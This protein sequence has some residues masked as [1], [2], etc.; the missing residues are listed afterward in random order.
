MK[1]SSTPVAPL[2]AAVPSALP[3]PCGGPNRCIG[4]PT[5]CA[6]FPCACPC[7]GRV[8]CRRS[9]QGPDSG[10]RCPESP[11]WSCGGSGGGGGCCFG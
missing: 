5:K 2:P 7:W 11:V 9:P 8:S 6:A 10:A 3:T 4:A 1:S